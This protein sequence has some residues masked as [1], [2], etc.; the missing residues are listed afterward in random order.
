MTEQRRVVLGAHGLPDAWRKALKAAGAGMRSRLSVVDA[1]GCDG[2]CEILL[3]L[4]AAQQAVIKDLRA[5]LDGAPARPASVMPVPRGLRLRF[6][7]PAERFALAWA[8]AAVMGEVAPDGA[9]Y[10]ADRNV[11]FAVVS[12]PVPQVLEDWL[13]FHAKEQGADA[14]LVVARGNGAP[15]GP[16]PGIKRLIWVTSPLPLGHGD[17]PAEASRYLA[18]D[19]PGQALLPPH[20]PD[21]ERSPLAEAAVLEAM[22]RRFL[23]KAR[24]VM[25]CHPS[26][27]VPAESGRVFDLAAERGFLRFSG[28]RAYPVALKGNPRHGDHV[29]V[30]FDGSRA[31]HIWC[32]APG[33]LAPDTLWRQFRVSGTPDPVS[34]QLSYWR[35]MG[36]RH[37]DLKLSELVP[38]S[39]LVPAPKLAALVARHF[40]A[41]EMEAPQVITTPVPER[42][43]D[44][45]LIVTTM[46]NEGPFILD[47][48]A[49]H[50]AI[51][52]T[53]FLVYTNDCDDGTD[54]FLECLTR[55]GLVQHRDN[56]FRQVDAKP[57]HAAL[58]D[59]EDRSVTG[60]VDW[61]IPMDVDE[62]IDVRL[63]E[64]RLADLFTALPDATMISM[65][66]RLFGNGDIARFED[67]PVHEQ[68]LLAAP[69]ICRKPHQAWGFKTLYRNL[70]HYRKLGVHRPKGLNPE[71]LNQINWVNGSGRPMPH[72]LYRT[73]WRSTTQ[74]FGYDMVSL[75][76]YSLRSA[77]SFLV[78]RDRGRVNHVDRD[79]GLAYW[80]RMNHNATDVRTILSKRAL[81]DAERAR[82]LAD[83][84]IADW[85]LRTVAAHRAKIDALMERPEFEA[86]YT[87]IT[88][89][90]LRALSRMLHH[91][92]TE[93]FL[94]GP[95][96]VPETFHLTDA[97]NVNL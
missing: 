2:G 54:H 19:G 37:P 28:Q 11:L 32:V 5:T 55:K 93:V 74:T 39:S 26:D 61:I 57:Q 85:H 18:P 48:L 86:L 88:G 45:V 72:S 80:F 42:K 59:A 62:Y 49:Y 79:Q 24:A 63:G 31:E 15:P 33:R 13:A 64:G 34:A 82:L 68:F 60:E 40:G 92:G 47:W 70:G 51:G 29:A 25:Y 69:E 43:N 27:L 89:E 30:S 65:T 17:E 94:E 12:D 41:A 96:A 97:E 56:P 76:H 83:E 1:Y 58:R 35:C 90:R 8:G 67:R 23:R 4:E 22:H 81:F 53:D 84:E 91:F 16:V 6:D 46:K 71:Y 75:N 87:A 52:V 21:P 10:L 7:Q 66:W 77:E 36:L 14:A 3:R 9:D 44:R 50:R 78:K 38:R 20:V 73:G 95:S